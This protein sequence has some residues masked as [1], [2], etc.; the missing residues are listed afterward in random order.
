MGKKFKQLQASIQYGDFYKG[1]ALEIKKLLCRYREDKKIIAVWGTGLKGNCFLKCFDAEAMYIDYAIDMNKSLHGSK[2]ATGHV[3]VG[4]DIFYN[5]NIDVVLVMNEVFYVEIYLKLK[6]RGF[7]GVILDVDRMIKRRMTAADIIA[8]K[9]EEYSADDNNMCGI[10]M[11]MVQE[12]VIEILKEV[13][14]VCKANDITYFLEAGSA[15]GAQRYGKMIPCDDDVDIAMLRSDYNR[16]LEIAPKELKSGYLLQ[17]MSNKSEFPYPY[18]QVVAD[19]TCFVRTRFQKL[20]MH[21]GI[22]IDVAPLDNVSLD[23]GLRKIQKEEVTKYTNLL[24]GRF[25]QQDYKSNNIIKRLIVN[26]DY[27]KMKCIPY[28]YVTKKLNK[29][30]LM[31]NNHETDMVGDL[32]THY[33]KDISF[34]KE[35]LLPVGELEFEGTMFP[36]PRDIDKYLTIMYDNYKLLSPREEGSTKYTLVTVSLTKNYHYGEEVYDNKRQAIY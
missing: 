29:A 32:C 14:R 27:Y 12:K 8:E 4:D 20:H 33:K 36:V 26:W 22:H 1:N 2:T 30:F 21:H 31:Y 11:R 17:T 5:T 19:G 3:I 10:T 9:E 34:Y 23:A 7:D 35:D 28:F 24:R 6:E 13:D 25:L 15:L 18:A 16:F